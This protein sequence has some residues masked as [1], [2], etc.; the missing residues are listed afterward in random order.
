MTK[1]SPLRELFKFRI[2]EF[3]REPEAV[4][5]VYVFPLLLIIG[6]G[7]AFSNRPAERVSVDIVE[8]PNARSIA[9][10]LKRSPDL[11]V[12]I[13]SEGECSQRLRFG[14]TA[15][16]LIPGN[17]YVFE[18]DPTRPEG[19]LA[20]QRVNDI[21]Q[22]AAGRQNPIT[23]ADKY[24]TEPG[25]RYIDFLVPG[26]LGMNLM[27]GGLWGVGYVIVDMRVRKLLKRF[28]ATPM[29]KADFLWSMIGGRLVFVIPELI[30][31][32]GSGVLLFG[33]PIRGNIFS[34]LLLA[35]I[36][37][38][39]FGGLGLFVACRAQKL[40]TVSGLMNLVLLPMW[41]LSGIFFSPER[42]PEI[43]QPIVQALPLTQLNYAM[44]EVILQ[45]YSLSS[46]LWRLMVVAAWGGISFLCALRWFRWN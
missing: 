35:L 2:R 25:T 36:G 28:I 10:H 18:F 22:E 13:H 12:A 34:I 33:V 27:G 5:W 1:Y 11:N 21:I 24:V 32:L 23:T 20:R 8:H 19:V 44:R 15:L 9:D 37:G 46:Q 3:I 41:L 7:I 38:I 31:I 45:G 29:R 43:I 30:V 16:V 26:L 4:F 39:S 42:F 40:E 17:P 14:K 6:L